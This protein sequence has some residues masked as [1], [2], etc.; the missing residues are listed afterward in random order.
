MHN[1]SFGTNISHCGQK[2]LHQCG[3]MGQSL[4]F[5][6]L[7]CG[8]AA[9]VMR[10]E[11]RLVEV[12]VLRVSALPTTV[13]VQICPHIQEV[14]VA[15]DEG[16]VVIQRQDEEQDCKTEVCSSVK[17]HCSGELEVIAMDR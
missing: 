8:K 15:T 6:Q 17:D 5:A 16:D 1:P 13:S 7:R 2:G 3:E 11:S 4:L 9:I 14:C 12:F 10:M